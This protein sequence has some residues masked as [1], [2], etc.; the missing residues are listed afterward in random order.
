MLK[1]YISLLMMISIFT[2]ASESFI[3][4]ESFKKKVE[5]LLPQS[6]V[7]AFSYS[8]TKFGFITIGVVTQ[9]FKKEVYY[10][11]IDASFLMRGLLVDT[12]SGEM[13]SQRHTNEIELD[14]TD[15]ANDWESAKGVSQGQGDDVIYVLVDANC[16]YCHKTYTDMQAALKSSS[17]NVRVKWIPLAMLGNDSFEKA[18]VLTS[19]NDDIESL[20]LLDQFMKRQGDVSQMPVTPVG[21]EALHN[22]QLLSKKYGFNGVP[23]VISRINDNWELH[24]GYP[25]PK[26]FEQLKSENVA[27]IMV[28]ETDSGGN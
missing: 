18:H 24:N 19:Q 28:K 16:G 17:N 2:H 9:Q 7:K 14:L 20:E 5:L 6:H 27:S 23:I 1:F 12:E 8:K 26:F 4:D 11:D 21:K 22:N 13:L 25:G 3:P 15:M 10:T